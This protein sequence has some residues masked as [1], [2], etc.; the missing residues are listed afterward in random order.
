MSLLSC[1]AAV[2]TKGARGQWGV[3]ASLL[4]TSLLCTLPGLP[5]FFCELTRSTPKAQGEEHLLAG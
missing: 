5:S 1:H 4:L 3:L 2:R